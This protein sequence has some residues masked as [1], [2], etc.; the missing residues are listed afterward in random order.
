MPWRGQAP[1]PPFFDPEQASRAARK[2]RWRKCSTSSFIWGKSDRCLKQLFNSWPTPRNWS[3][4]FFPQAEALPALRLRR[5]SESA[6]QTLRQ[7]STHPQRPELS[8]SASPLFGSRP[9]GRLR[10]DFLH[11]PLRGAATPHR[12]RAA[13]VAIAWQTADRIIGSSR[14][15]GLA[16]SFC[17]GE[18]L[19]SIATLV[20]AL[21]GFALTALS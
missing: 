13:A 6:Q 11:F 7:R 2:C 15:P 9:A 21:A 8:R 4:S 5:E 20:R 12:A 1:P 16:G 17:A 14:R 19:S 18:L 3:R 10:K